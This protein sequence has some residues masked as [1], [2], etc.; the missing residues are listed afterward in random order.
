MRKFLVSVVCAL[1]IVITSGANADSERSAKIRT[2][3]NDYAAYQ[4]AYDAG[5]FAAALIK[6]QSTYDLGSELFDKSHPNLIGLTYNLGYVLLATGE[7]VKA[8]PYLE[9]ALELSETAYKDSNPERLIPVLMDLADAKARAFEP[10]TVKKEFSRALRISEKVYGEKSVEFARLNADIA[11]EYTYMIRTT[12]GRRYIN[13]SL[14]IMAEVAG[15]ASKEYA[16]VAFEK[17]KYE[18]GQRDYKDAERYFTHALEV[19]ESPEVSADKLELSSHAFLTQ[20]YQ[21]TDR[22]AEATKHCLAI[23]RASPAVNV[24]EMMPIVRVVPKYPNKAARQGAQGWVD[25][26]FDV[27]ESGF[28]INP[29]VT[30]SGGDKGFFEDSA[31]EAIKKHRYAPAFKDGKSILTEGVELRLIYEMA[32]G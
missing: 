27:D 5:D 32:E 28:V 2:F 3:K 23:G 21:N 9:T 7:R 24:R 19:F 4:A 30:G 15:T 1:C 8:E 17:A 6:A 20:V 13:R 11:R 26:Q 22:E 12:D 31:L 29:V 16:L 25:L 14:E 10:R 18:F